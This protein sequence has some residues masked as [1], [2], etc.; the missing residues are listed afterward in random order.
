MRNKVHHIFWFVL[1]T[2]MIFACRKSDFIIESSDIVVNDIGNGTGTVTWKKNKE[3]I[4]EGKVFVN[5]GQVLTIEPGTVIK[6]RQ[7]QGAASSA[8]IVARGGKIIAEGTAVDPI[9]F[10]AEGD[11]LSGALDENDRGLWGG[12]ILLGNAPLNTLNSEAHIEGIPISEPRGIYGGQT[13]EDNS[14][15]LKYVSIRHTGTDLGQDNEINGLTLGGVGNATTVEDI[16]IIASADDGIEIFGGTVNIKRAVVVNC[17]DDAIDI[18]QGYQGNLQFLCL[19]Q[20]ENYGDKLLEIDGATNPITALPY[21]RPI[22]YNVTGIGRGSLISNSL[23][24][25]RNNASGTIANSIFVDQNKGIGIEY[26]SVR[27]NSYSQLENKDLNL[28]NNI[29]H[30]VNESKASELFYITAVNDEDI[31]ALQSNLNQYFFNAENRIADPEFSTSESGYFLTSV[32]DVV[33]QS[34]A[35]TPSVYFDEAPYKGAFG[36]YN[37]VG[38]WSLT[39]QLKNVQ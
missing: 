15:I 38:D 5:D 26:S 27:L 30:N 11:N 13:P 37:W 33:F 22:I 18:D 20:N 35:S 32:S 19:I 24:V 25:F 8:L 39:G 3:Y 12:I 36:N 7:G 34:P 31:T 23:V 10:T 4:L 21:T 9:I 6:A 16:E 17:S 14:G 2:L 28:K 29:F 1:L